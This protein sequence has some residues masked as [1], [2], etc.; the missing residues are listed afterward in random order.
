[1]AYEARKEET[2]LSLVRIEEILPLRKISNFTRLIRIT[3]RIFRFAHNAWLKENRV[4]TPLTTIEL[5]SS[6]ELWIRRSQSQSFTTEIVNITKGKP[7]VKLI[8]CRPFIDKKGVIRAG[9]RTMHVQMVFSV[10][11]PIILHGK[12]P[13]VRLVIKSEHERLLHT[14]L[15]LTSAS[16]HWKYW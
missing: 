10:H 7:A 1:M 2:E 16:L 4:N 9:G 5:I 15:T 6:Q 11:H 3:A 8:Q 12:H 13:L 14:G